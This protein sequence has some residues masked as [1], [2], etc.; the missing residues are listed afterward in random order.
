MIPKEAWYRGLVPQRR[1]L[2]QA[3]D[4]AL[5]VNLLK[6]VKLKQAQV[7]V[8]YH[9]LKGYKMEWTPKHRLSIVLLLQG[10]FEMKLLEALSC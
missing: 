8:A 1:Q 4:L 10:A 7:G 3:A 6:V 2:H 5:P 9:P